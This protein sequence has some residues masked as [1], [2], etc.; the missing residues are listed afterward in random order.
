MGWPANIININII[1]IK[2]NNL[3]YQY[4]PVLLK[5]GL[6]AVAPLIPTKLCWSWAS[7]GSGGLPLVLLIAPRW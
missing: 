1:F 4:S 5:G 2:E 3:Q 6:T 7:Q